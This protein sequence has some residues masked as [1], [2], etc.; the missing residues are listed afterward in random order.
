MSISAQ[1][2]TAF[3]EMLSSA[4]TAHQPSRAGSGSN[5]AGALREGVN[6]TTMVTGG[7]FTAP[8]PLGM[9]MGDLGDGHGVSTGLTPFLNSAY[10]DPSEAHDEQD[11][12]RPQIAHINS[13]SD[14]SGPSRRAS[15][16]MGTGNGT[17]SRQ[18]SG[19]Y[20][21]SAVPPLTPSAIFN[22][23]PTPSA[24]G[25]GGANLQANGSAQAYMPQ[26]DDQ[27]NLKPSTK[28][29]GPW[30]AVETV[31][32]YLSSA[33]MGDALNGQ[34]Q[35]PGHFSMQDAAEGM[36]PDLPPLDEAL[37]QQLLMDLFWPGWPVNLPEPNV[38]NDL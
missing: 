30:R 37:Q 18:S 38:V 6:G 9:G 21:S 5:G 27:G 22:F 24:P 31:D 29:D 20:T 19:I 36:L 25:D 7:V 15:D 28:L 33:G 13:A 26:F 8:T 35:G 16:S 4:A 10:D 11:G 3:L 12:D 1:S 14:A 34:G 23:P 17:S 2:P 32:T